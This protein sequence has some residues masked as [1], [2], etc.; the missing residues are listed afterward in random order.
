MPERVYMEVDGRRDHAFPVPRPKRSTA[1]GAPDVCQGCHT[2]RVEENPAWA[3]EQIASWRTSQ[4]RLRPHWAD[5]LTDELVGGN[6]VEGWFEIAIEPAW[7]AIVRA[8]AWSRLAREVGGSPP[9][10]LLQER[11]REGSELERLALIEVAPLL[12]PAMRASFLRPLLEDELRSVRIAAAAA[13]V[14]VPASAFRPSDREPLAHALGEYRA[15]QEA[16]AE[17]PE[18]QVNLGTLAV[19]YGELDAARASYLR[20]LDQAP[21]FVPAYANLADLERALGRDREAVAWL[22]QAVELAPEVAMTRYALGLALH[23]L[24]ETDEA[25]SQLAMAAA[26]APDQPRLVLGWAL[27][28]DAAGQ[29]SRAI[30]VLGKAVDGGLTV[31]DL[32]HALVTLQRDSGNPDAARNRAAE[33]VAAWPND[34]RASALLRELSGPR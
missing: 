28:L 10:D 22:R 15:A 33:W 16:N 7:P 18:A 23:R 11:L 5:R 3:E 26:A 32:Y 4:T 14:G 20:A 8:T 30:S 24:G 1:L 29:R 27:A 9:L 13:L 17:R 34:P 2:D 19:Q 31:P 25:L 12:A 21:Y 6:D